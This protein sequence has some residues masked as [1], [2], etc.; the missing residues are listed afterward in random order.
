MSEDKARAKGNK[1]STITTLFLIIVFSVGVFNY[2]EQNGMTTRTLILILAVVLYTF[3]FFRLKA[4]SKQQRQSHEDDKTF[5][6]FQEETEDGPDGEISEDALTRAISNICDLDERKYTIIKKMPIPSEDGVAEIDYLL[7]HESGF[8]IFESKDEPCEIAGHRNALLY[9]LK[10]NY[11]H[12]E[13][14]ADEVPI[15][16]IV[17]PSDESALKEKLEPLLK[18]NETFFDEKIMRDLF[19][20]LV[21]ANDLANEIR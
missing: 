9:F 5:I 10:V 18:A 20:K 21:V 13:L 14:N 17:M 1:I 19:W 4:K 15:Y 8:Y 3:I 16:S 7:F 12:R 6:N 2:Y 11:S